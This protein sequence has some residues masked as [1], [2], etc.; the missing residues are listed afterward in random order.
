[1]DKKLTLQEAARMVI[2]FQDACNLSGVVHVCPRIVTAVWDEATKQEKGTDWVNTH[3]VV[4]M[5]V[6]K[7]CD[8]SRYTYGNESDNFCKAYHAVQLLAEGRAA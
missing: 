7:L 8:L 4:L 3:P 5:M 6:S 2:Q 1:M